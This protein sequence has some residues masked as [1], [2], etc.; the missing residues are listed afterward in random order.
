ML[1]AWRL[2][3]PFRSQSKLE[4]I[5]GFYGLIGPN[6]TI[7]EIGNLFD[8]FTGNGLIQGVFLENGRVTP[9]STLVKTKKLIFEEQ[10]G[11]FKKNRLTFHILMSWLGIIPNI[12]GVANTAILHT[13][14]HTYA[15]AERDLPY[16][17][18]V[19]FSRKTVD[20]VGLTPIGHVHAVSAHSR[21]KNGKIRSF[22]YSVLQRKVTFSTICHDCQGA[23]VES[24]F[25]VKTMYV[26]MVHDALYLNKSVMFTDSPF[27]FSLSRLPVLD[28]TR[29]TFIHVIKEEPVRVL[30][31]FRSE[32][33]FYIFHYAQVTEDEES[34]EIFAPLY[35]TLD[36]QTISLQGKY[37][38]LLLDKRTM[39]IH[40]QKN[41]ELELL[42]LEFPVKY[43]DKVILRSVNDKRIDSF[44]ICKGL[45]IKLVIK[46]RDALSICGEPALYEGDGFSRILCLAYDAGSNGYF[47]LIDP[48]T[49]DVYENELGIK[50]TIGFHS[51]FI[52]NRQ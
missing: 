38:R 51:V 15:L 25:L 17:I 2:R 46:V 35:D 42:N 21:W 31:M 6:M 27:H 22:E 39:K 48:E 16:E 33:A 43:K 32:V 50:V 12:L 24:S 40:I 7:S 3:F 5:N 34:I 49:G 26:P 4:E 18:R 1:E 36:F 23:K 13:D 11:K 29:P 52:A 20:T 28:T 47:L 37:R 45:D 41:E 8:L 10:W 9:V 44:V 30:R 19:D 14:N